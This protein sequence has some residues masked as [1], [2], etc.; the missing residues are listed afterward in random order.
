MESPSFKVFGVG[1]PSFPIPAMGRTKDIAWTGTN[2]WGVSS[3]LYKLTPEDLKNS[4]TRKEVFKPRFTS[5][6]FEITVTDTDYGPLV[7]DT[8]FL[9]SKD[10]LALKWVGHRPSMEFEALLKATKA[11]DVFEFRKALKDFS[12]VA[13][14]YVVADKKGNIS[15]VHAAHLPVLQNHK[16]AFVQDPTNKIVKYQTVMNLPERLN[17]KRGYVVSANEFNAEAEYSLCWFC[18]TADRANRISSLLKDGKVDIPRI[19]KIHVDI[20]SK[21]AKEIFDFFQQEWKRF[22]LEQKRNFNLLKEW[23]FNYSVDAKQP[24]LYEELIRRFAEQIYTKAGLTK[25]DVAPLFENLIWKK[26]VIQWYKNLH[27]TD[28]KYVLEKTQKSFYRLHPK[29]WG[30]VH[31]IE[32]AHPLSNVP[33]LGDSYRYYRAG[34]PGSSNTVFKAA[35]GYNGDY[36]VTF[37]ANLRVIFDMNDE[38]ENY[39]VL[40]GGQDGYLGSKT[41][42]D[43]IPTWIDGEYY[44]VPFRTETIKKESVRVTTLKVD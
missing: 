6:E 22:D 12:V 29:K 8:T 26:A 14:N 28:Q 3:F 16:K 18:S 24:Y 30:K 10:P 2:M 32:A 23:D 38:D 27:E 33:V 20:Y 19:K 36:K 25:Q 39:A 21:E 11:K 37:G 40:L 41:F 1:I 7:S 9:K 35:H 44:K 42:A 15:K 5:K 13:I 4:V 31:Q 43:Q 34:Y 17:P